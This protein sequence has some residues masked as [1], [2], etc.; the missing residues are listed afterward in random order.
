MGSAQAKLDALGVDGLCEL[1]GQ[2]LSLTSIAEQHGVAVASLIN[3]IAADSERSARVREVREAM[4]KVWDEQAEAE[5]RN[6]TDDLSMKKA[7]ELAHHFRWRAKAMAPREYGDRQQI[8]H[9]GKVGLEALVAGDSK[10]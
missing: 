3:W 6:A 5:I 1:I 4:A 2:R 8:E 10:E 9:S 7:R